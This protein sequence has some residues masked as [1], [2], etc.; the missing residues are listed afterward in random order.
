MGCNPLLAAARA[1]E[2]HVYVVSSTHTDVNQGWMIS[3]VFGQDGRTLAQA[4]DWGTVAIAEVDL[5]RRLHW[6]SLGDFK[7]ELPRHR[8]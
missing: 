8:P 7:A 2:N 1:A 4:R 6:S 5:A 3:A